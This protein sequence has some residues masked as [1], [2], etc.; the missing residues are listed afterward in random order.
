MARD[1]RPFVSVFLPVGHL[2][3]HVPLVLRDCYSAEYYMRQ[4]VLLSRHYFLLLNFLYDSL[5]SS[6][7]RLVS[8]QIH[9]SSS[10]LPFTCSDAL[11]P[12]IGMHSV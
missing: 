2:T 7:L 5:R 1:A 10:L 6:L 4:K 8:L 12:H 11:C 9:A 3:F